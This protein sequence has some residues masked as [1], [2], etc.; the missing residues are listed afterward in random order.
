LLRT[1]RI[2]IILV[3]VLSG[4]TGCRRAPA[5]VTLERGGSGPPTLVLLHGYGSSADEWLPF[6]ATI[7]L[8]EG[9]RFVFPQA[10]GMSAPARSSTGR[11]WWQ[12]DLA[13][14]RGSI[15]GAPDLSTT[16]PPGLKIAASMVRDLIKDLE[17][18]RGKPIVLGGFSQGAMVAAEVALQS[19][20]ELDGLVLLSGTL[21]DEAAWQQR[22]GKLRSVPVFMSHGRADPVLPFAIAERFRGQMVAAGLNVTWVPFGGGHEMPMTVVDELNQFVARIPSPRRWP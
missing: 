1:L 19:D 7:R 10:P 6:V 17:R 16:Q 5:L 4:T 15:D 21:V 8:P 2:V 22:F 20:V 12:L 3:G 13:L 18:T 9:G 14:Q 11:A